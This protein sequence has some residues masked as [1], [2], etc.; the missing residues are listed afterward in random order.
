MAGDIDKTEGNIENKYDHNFQ[1]RFCKCNAAYDINQFM[2]R[3]LHCLDF[4]HLFHLG[5]PEEI[6]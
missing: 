2:I 6:V 3:C 4:F 5:L 1:A